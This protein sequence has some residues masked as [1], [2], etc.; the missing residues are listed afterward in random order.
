MPKMTAI[1]PVFIQFSFY[2]GL[3]S[4]KTQI[5]SVSKY[6]KEP[7]ARAYVSFKGI[8]FYRKWSN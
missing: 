1:E 4:P 8:G 5:T 7:S 2:I 6:P 3:F